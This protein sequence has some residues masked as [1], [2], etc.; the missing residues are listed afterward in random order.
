MISQG[1][2][3]IEPASN[4]RNLMRQVSA[5]LK[6]RGAKVEEID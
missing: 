3:V 2:A 4:L 1:V 5:L 6:A